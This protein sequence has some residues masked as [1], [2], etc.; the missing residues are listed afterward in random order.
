[1]A[2][3]DYQRLT[4]ID[5]ISV[6]LGIG[7]GRLDFKGMSP[8]FLKAPAAVQALAKQAER[9]RREEAR[10]AWWAANRPADKPSGLRDRRPR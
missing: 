6:H 5:V 9:L 8:L 4:S 2:F 10:V 1:M 7:R 3:F